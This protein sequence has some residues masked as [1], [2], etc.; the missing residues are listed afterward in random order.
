MADLYIGLMSGTSADGIDAVLMA[1]DPAPRLL[2]THFTPYAG[3]V[4]KKVRA[5]S[6]GRHAGDPVDELGTLDTELGELFGAAVLALLEGSKTDPKSVRAIGSHGQ[7]VRHRPRIA[8]PFTAQIADPNVI[9]ART[10]IT[11]VADFRRRDVALGGQGAP[12]LPA[13]HQV[14]F[15]SATEERVVVNVGGIA[16]VTLLPPAEPVRGFDTGPGNVLMDWVCR[17]RLGQAYDADGAHAARGGIDR[18]LLAALMEDGYFTQPI[19][20]STGPEHFN[21][22]WLEKV[23]GGRTLKTEDLLATLTELTARS[24]AEQVHEHAAEAKHVYVCGGGAHNAHLM[25]RLASQF[26][27][28]PVEST[29]ALGLDPDW[30]EAAGFAWLAQRTLVG[31]PGNLPSVTGAAR[32]TIL[33]A[34]HP[35]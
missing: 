18:P 25:A 21:R 4:R 3:S 17:E 10:G 13:F 30:V 8:H 6:Q 22:E 35:A 20:K 32:A 24:V 29:A 14:A 1:F 11:V 31:Q 19:P 5:L 23:L 15:G 27:S 7:T 28:V 9:A 34:I 2:A 33:G 26:P 12:L 16:N